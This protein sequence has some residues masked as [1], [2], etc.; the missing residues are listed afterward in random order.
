M[1]QL[2]LDDAAI[3]ATI[4]QLLPE[5]DA[6]GV[7]PKLFTLRLAYRLTLERLAPYPDN[8]RRQFALW[9]VEDILINGA[10]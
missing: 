6:Q 5:L 8:M 9:L 7:D 2:N 10:S 3:A 1:R 4:D